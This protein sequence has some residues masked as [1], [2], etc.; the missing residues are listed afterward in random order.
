MPDR[1]AGLMALAIA[2]FGMGL[3]CQ[4]A[5]MGLLKRI[6][7]LEAMLRDEL[8]LRQSNDE[9]M[10]ERLFS[11]ADHIKANLEKLTKPKVP[12][13]DPFDRHLEIYHT[14]DGKWTWRSC[15]VGWDE[16]SYAAYDDLEAW[17][18]SCGAH[19][20]AEEALAEGLKA[21]EF[22]NLMEP[23]DTQDEDS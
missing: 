2:F 9:R 19:D 10:S 8:K 14:S 21:V 3:M 22:L 5:F 13:A 20:T 17:G 12:K 23:E 6:E 18:L 16:G 11:L 4:W 7:S 1:E 15:Y